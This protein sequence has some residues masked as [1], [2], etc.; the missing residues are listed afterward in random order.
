[1][2]GLTSAR[3]WGIVEAPKYTDRRTASAIPAFPPRAGKSTRKKHCWKFCI[4]RSAGVHSADVYRYWQVRCPGQPQGPGSLSVGWG[5]P[6]LPFFIFNSKNTEVHH[7][8][9]FH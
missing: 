6:Y 8:Q 9:L 3:W 5:A 4:S 7:G 1:M 2:I